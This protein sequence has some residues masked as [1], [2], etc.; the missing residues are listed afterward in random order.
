MAFR[1]PRLPK[2]LSLVDVQRRVSREFQQWWQKAMEAIENMVLD[3]QEAIDRITS[4]ESHIEDLE[5]TTFTAGNGL[6]GGGNILTNPAFAVGAGTG[7]LVGADAVSVSAKLQAYDGGDTPSAFTLGI[8]DSVDAAAWRAAIGAGTG[9]GTVTSVAASVP[10]GFTISGSPITTAGTLAITYSAGY[11]GYTST[12]ATKLAGIATGATANTGTVTSVNASGGTTGYSFTGGPVTTS[13]T[14][15]LTGTPSALG[16]PATG[17]L[18][19]CTG[20]PIST[21]VAGLGANVAAFLATPSSANLAAAVTDED[22]SGVLPFETTGTWTPTASAASGT[23]TA[24]TA[25]GQYTKTGRVVTATFS[26]SIT[27]NGT[28]AG[29]LFVTLPFATNASLTYYGG[30]RESAAGAMLQLETFAGS[31]ACQ[32]VTYN[33]GYP[34]STGNTVKCTVT[35]AV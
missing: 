21:G 2:D 33:N 35:Y 24:Y 19:N 11:Q 16:T 10:T 5:A 34:G 4:S 18:T 12:E 13:G 26:V 3:L 30:G 9:S 31:A 25:T 15:T 32:V 17:T 20:L 6:T 7:I 23:I 29:A 14:L 28:A 27:T 8:V 22:G 1:L